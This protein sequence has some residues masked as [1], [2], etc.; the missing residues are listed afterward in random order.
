MAPSTTILRIGLVACL[1]ASPLLAQDFVRSPSSN[2]SRSLSE[3]KSLSRAF[4]S[5]TDKILPSVVK[6]RSIANGGERV[7]VG[8]LFPMQIPEQ[9]GLGSGVIIDP[10]GIVMTNNH[11]VKDADQVV[12]VLQD[13]T[14]LF[15]TEYT[16]DPLTDLA[17]VR[18]KSKTPLPAAQLGDSD[19]LKIGDW[20]LA[21]GHPLE[22]ETSVSAGIISAKGRSLSKIPRAQFLQTDAAINPGNSGG[23]LVNLQGEVIGINTAIAS[24]TGGYQG[25]G[26]A[27]PASIARDVV[28]QL[29]DNGQVTRGYLGV[30]IQNLTKELSE[31][32]V[33]RPRFSGVVVNKVTKGT[34]A[35]EAGVRAGDVITHFANVPVD[36]PSAL[37]RA[38]ERVPVGSQQ[39]L[40][41]VRFGRP[42]AANVSTL[43]FDDQFFDRRFQSVSKKLSIP[44]SD[45]SSLGF[46]VADLAD[47]ARRQ[48]LPVDGNAVLITRVARDGLAADRNIRPGMM[49][50]QVRDRVVN[51]VDEFYAA[52]RNES[53]AEGI[54][55]LVRETDREGNFSERFVVVRAY[56]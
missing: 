27:V 48:G 2:A 31:Q 44:V 54:L 33:D 20:V 56:Q 12:V 46:E 7:M 29:R 30:S 17:I 9:E 24:Q 43:R 39:Q 3:A 32:L 10:S 52:L 50:K 53:L 13:G 49:I 18:V 11:V 26:F 42:M 35:E 8:G 28:R 45:N 4:Q 51:N 14:E 34:P 23:P 5:A 1:L 55:L 25:I 40:R 16:T 15:G 19:A 37:Q 6:I 47:L 38:V 22:L 36:S 21:V 41:F